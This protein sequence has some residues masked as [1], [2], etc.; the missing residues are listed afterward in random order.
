L[1]RLRLIESTRRYV[2]LKKRLGS[3]INKGSVDFSNV[4]LSPII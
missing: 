3:F 2:L 4:V 1:S